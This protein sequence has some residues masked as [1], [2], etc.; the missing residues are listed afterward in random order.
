M[1]SQLIPISIPIPSSPADPTQFDAPPNPFPSSLPTN[2]S[3]QGPHAD[4]PAFHLPFSVLDGHDEQARCKEHRHHLHLRGEPS[5]GLGQPP[6]HHC[7][8]LAV[9][10]SGWQWA[11]V[12]LAGR[13]KGYF[14][15]TFS[16]HDSWYSS[17]FLAY[18]TA[19][20]VSG[21]CM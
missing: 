1:I 9:D 8:C 16:G 17:I 3:E 12:N 21:Y 11:E 7:C 4:R 20:P 5:E 2:Q 6:R 14:L 18:V 13:R 15:E 19:C 10:G